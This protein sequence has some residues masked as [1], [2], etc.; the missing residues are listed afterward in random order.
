MNELVGFS[1]N[2][3]RV[4]TPEGTLV[5]PAKVDMDTF[6]LLQLA[7]WELFPSTGIQRRSFVILFSLEDHEYRLHEYLRTRNAF[8]IAHHPHILQWDAIA[9]AAYATT[10]MQ[11]YITITNDSDPPFILETPVAIF[12]AVQTDPFDTTPGTDG[13]DYGI[14]QE[15]EATIA[16]TRQSY[17]LEDGISRILSELDVYFDEP[18]ETICIPAPNRFGYRIVFPYSRELYTT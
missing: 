13:K 9:H 7:P 3:T 2:L 12:Q 15:Y 11:Q 10:L 14:F 6:S 5:L 8:N 1:T 4:V 16:H 18:L 17:R